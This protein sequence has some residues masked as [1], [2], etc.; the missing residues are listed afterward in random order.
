MHRYLFFGEQKVSKEKQKK[1]KDYMRYGER[2]E[3]CWE[4]TVQQR[5]RGEIVRVTNIRQRQNTT[6][7]GGYTSAVGPPQ[8]KAK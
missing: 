6:G 8:S 4:K 1:K 5:S 7:R 3:G 2:V